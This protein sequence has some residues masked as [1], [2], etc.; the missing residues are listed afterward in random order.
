M[1]RYFFQIHGERGADDDSAGIALSS[2]STAM[3]YAATMCA[4]IGMSGGFC[5]DFA[6]SVQDELGAAI[7]R[8]S[9]VVAT[10]ASEQRDV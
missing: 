7:G 4:E 8:V 3:L 6:V 9:V 1:Q 2:R 5:L 10:A